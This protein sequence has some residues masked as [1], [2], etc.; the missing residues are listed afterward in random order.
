MLRTD[1][2]MRTL[3]MKS[4]DDWRAGSRDVSFENFFRD[5]LF[6]PLNLLRFLNRLNPRTLMKRITKDLIG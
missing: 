6:E 2:N 1:E 4:V 5:F 3:L